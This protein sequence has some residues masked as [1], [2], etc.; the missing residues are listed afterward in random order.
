MNRNPLGASGNG[1]VGLGDPRSEGVEFGVMLKC[2]GVT[3]FVILKPMSMNEGHFGS[4]NVG[5]HP[6][7]TSIV[8]F[9]LVRHINSKGL[10][11]LAHTPSKRQRQML[12]WGQTIIAQSLK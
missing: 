6:M 12:K 5:E 2:T 4:S 9:L 10:F 7:G 8:S 11:M 3:S 1:M